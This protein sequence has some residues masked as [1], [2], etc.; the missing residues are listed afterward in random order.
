MASFELCL[1][2]GCDGFEFDVRRSADGQA[3]ICHDPVVQGREISRTPS[4]NLRLPMLDE[5]LHSFGGRAF[6]DIELKVSGLECN[7]LAL[8]RERTAQERHVVSSFLPEVLSALH[9]L[10]S[11]VP[12][13]LI[14]ETRAQLNR[15]RD[16]SVAW[17]MP[18]F[19]LVDSVL[20][21]ELQA[22]GIK[23]MVWTVNQEARLREFA[24][25]GV[26]AVISD[27]TELAARVL[28]AP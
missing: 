1:E 19:D 4:A 8:L 11:T 17:V 25:L 28:F 15:W 27:E 3:V 12:L 23:I 26:H 6:L 20:F 21:G 2:H 7:T 18:Q 24:K 13:G 10:D 22:A 5:V 14:C 16:L 9:K